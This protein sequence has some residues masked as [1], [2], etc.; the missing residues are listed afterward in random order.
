MPYD[1]FERGPLPVGVRT[2][3]LR[4]D[5]RDRPL[6]VEVWYPADRAHAGAD[7]GETTKD[8]YELVPGLPS[9]TQDAVRDARPAGSGRV[10]LVVFSHGFG[11]HRRQTTF[12][13]TH[14]ASH[15]YVVAAVDHTGNTLHDV[16]EMT[17]AALSG[18]AVPEPLSSLP[19]FIEARPRDVAFLIDRVLDGAAGD[20]AAIVDP[21]RI[22]MSGHSFGG[23]T[24]LAVTR[25][26]RRVRA[27]LPLAPAGGATPMPVDP[28]RASLD[29]A[30]GR[31]VPTLFLV[32]ERDSLLPLTGMHELLEKTPAAAKRMVVIENADHLHFC[33]RA[34]EVHEMFRLMPPPGA[35]AAAARSTPPIDELCPAAH[36]RD[37]IRGL[38]LAHMDAVL[39]AHAGAAALVAGDVRSLLGDRGIRVAVHRSVGPAQMPPPPRHRRPRRRPPPR[40]RWRRPRR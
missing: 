40:R 25:A 17:R 5:A 8:R 32:A 29:F 24:T 10:P 19:T 2:A 22:G 12:L 18:A 15:G 35:F 37:A 36:A 4:D 3:S 34:E 23:W 11:S 30:W 16:L 9:V 31:E 21:D 14:L 13:C 6:A 28:L 1:P 39:K 26:D 7:L 38:G 33:D 20:V 27:A